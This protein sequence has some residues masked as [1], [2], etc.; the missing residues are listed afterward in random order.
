MSN[1]SLN[2]RRKRL[3]YL[4]KWFEL[5]IRPSDTECFDADRDLLNRVEDNLKELLKRCIS[6]RH[7]MNSSLPNH[8][9]A[10][11]H[12]LKVSESSIANAGKG[13][14]FEPK[15][16]DTQQVIQPGTIICY[17]TGHH[18]NYQSVKTL[19]DRS[20]LMCISGDVFVDPGPC[21]QIKARYINDPIRIDAINCKYVPEPHYFRSAVVATKVILPG[22]ELFVSYG[23]AYWAQQNVEAT[24]YKQI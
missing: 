16:I 24:S 9:L 14:F 13:L 8:E 4:E 11:D 19:D 15:F 23:E 18:H 10:L 6:A 5:A 1:Q 17:Y 12:M 3:F 21:P 7:E 22:E 20:Y 2:Q